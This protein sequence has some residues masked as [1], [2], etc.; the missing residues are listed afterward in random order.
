MSP[1]F[2]SAMALRSLARVLPKWKAWSL[3]ARDSQVLKEADYLWPDI[4][5]KY[6]GSLVQ[7]YRRRSR[8]GQDARPSQAYQKWFDS[9]S[10][11]KTA[12]LL[13]ALAEI[14][15]LLQEA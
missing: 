9:L 10:A 12:Q 15:Y 1:D 11:A 4:E 8:G 13:P 5:P 7:N 2:F 3:K 6:L 14:G